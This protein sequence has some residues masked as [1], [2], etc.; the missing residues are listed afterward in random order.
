MV[1]RDGG[2]IAE[3]YDQELDQLR[4]LNTTAETFLAE[5]ELL[6]RER[7]KIPTLKVGYNRI[8]G[9]YIEITHAQAKDLPAEYIRRQTLKPDELTAKQA[10][11]LV[12]ALCETI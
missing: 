6:E 3:G 10:L 7:T 11:E 2:V 9:F 5:L 12:Y 8:H 1:I 4:C